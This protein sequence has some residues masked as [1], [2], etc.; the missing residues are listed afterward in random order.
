[1]RGRDRPAALRRLRAALAQCQALGPATNIAFLDAVAR[2]AAYAAGAVDTGFIARHRD[3]LLPPAAPATDRD[4]ALAALYL[5]LARRAEAASAA[6]QSAD[7]WS[8][9]HATDGWRLN[10]DSYHALTFDDPS[11]GERAAI[12]AVAHFRG[13]DFAIELPTGTIAARGALAADGT[14]TAVL[15]G[16]RATVTVVRRGQS[17]YLIE[18]AA[19]RRLDVVDPMAGAEARG[20]DAG[21]LQAPMPG[22]ITLVRAAAGDRVRRGQVLMVMEAMKMEHSVAAPRD[23]TIKEVRYQQGEQVA[24]GEA[25]IVFEEEEEG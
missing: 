20:A 7:P 3:A 25:L 23:G 10:G 11:P 12:R 17:L 4:L 8:P 22:K 15:D 5:M 13:A 14:L 1:V 16:V 2:H 9:W 19:M 24:E 21:R 18:G 6:G